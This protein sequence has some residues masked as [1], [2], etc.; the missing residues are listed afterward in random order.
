MTLDTLFYFLGVAAGHEIVARPVGACL[1]ERV[2]CGGL[3]VSGWVAGG[4]A[5]GWWDGLAGASGSESAHFSGSASG[6][7]GREPGV[8]RQLGLFRRPRLTTHPP[9]VVRPGPVVLSGPARSPSASWLQEPAPSLR[10]WWVAPSRRRPC[11]QSPHHMR[12]S[13]SGTD[14]D[15]GPCN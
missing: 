15:G 9:S 7:G 3:A 14:F 2:A 1:G 5:G 11:Q 6:G 8:K 10:T 12:E 13:D 4:R